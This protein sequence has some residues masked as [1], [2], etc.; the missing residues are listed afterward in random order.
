MVNKTKKRG[1]KN[2]RGPAKPK[3]ARVEL[4]ARVESLGRH[5]DG[6]AVA[7]GGASSD[8]YFVPFALPGE[9]VRIRAAGTRAELIEILEPSSDRINAFCPHY[10]RCGGC[11]SQHLDENPYKVWKQKIVETALQN[12]GLGVA[13]DQMVDAHGEGRRRVTFHAIL[14]Q[15]QTKIGFMQSRSRQLTEISACPILSPTLI[16]AT[17][18]ARSLAT[19]FAA[20]HHALDL[21]LTVTKEGLDCDIQGV[22]DISY[23]VHV[24][25]AEQADKWDLARITIDGVMELERRK[26]YLS[27]GSSRIP[28][29]PASFLQATLQGENTLSS[30]VCEELEGAKKVADLFCGIGPYALRLA[31]TASVYA[32]DSNELA[33][34]ALQAAQRQ[35]TGLKP[36]VAE[37]RDL[38]RNPLYRDDLDDFDAVVLNPAR[39][40]AQ[41]QSEEIAQSSTPLVVYVSCDPATLARDAEILENGGFQLTRI[42]PVD[43]FKY[44]SHIETVSVFRRH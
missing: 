25:L 27:I 9:L 2:K 12:K 5:C 33:I 24:A 29:P 20:T 3:V 44:S 10:S 39:A 11:T 6:V 34:D 14:T 42:T 26:P 19:P 7:D 18:I 30:R 16:N 36:I 13:I 1:R 41:A 15:R 40:G 17:E 22:E 32:A 4:M 37:V 21:A 31:E 38:F 8:R 23:D 43:Q 28:L 35:N